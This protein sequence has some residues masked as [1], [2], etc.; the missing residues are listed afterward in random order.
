MTDWV[1]RINSEYLSLNNIKT[2]LKDHIAEYFITSPTDGVEF[3][4]D[5]V[6][7]E[8]LTAENDVTDHYVES[9][10]AYQDQITRKPKIYTIQGEV[11]ELVWYQRDS[12]SQNIGQV[13]QRLEG[14]I[15]FLPIRS[16]GFNQM[17]KKV[18]Q[19]AQWVDTASNIVSRLSDIRTAEDSLEIGGTKQEQAYLRL[20]EYRENIFRPLTVKTPWGILQDYVIT[21]LRFTQPRETRDKSLISITLKEF[22]TTS[23]APAKFDAGKYQGVAGLENEPNTNSGT[24]SGEDNSI[25]RQVTSEDKDNPFYVEGNVGGDS[26]TE[27]VAN[28]T[29]GTDKYKVWYDTKNKW[30]IIVTHDGQT[31]GPGTIKDQVCKAAFKS[32]QDEMIRRSDTE[33]AMIMGLK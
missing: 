33:Y 5:I 8:T 26:R 3:K 17:K 12:L 7:E 4:L 14:V 1:G 21:S 31:I 11:G 6:G 32:I 28:V 13:A 2:A 20:L 23:V 10:V 18:M 29:D 27:F 9:N 19:A 22:R 30:D 15:S 16:S 25:S 24:V